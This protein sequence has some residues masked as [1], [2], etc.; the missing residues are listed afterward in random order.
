MGTAKRLGLVVLLLACA[1]PAT[2]SAR[3]R[4]VFPVLGGAT[5][6]DDFGEPR[7]QGAHEGNDLMARKRTP[8]VACADGVVTLHRS[9]RAGF[10]LYLRNRRNEFLYIHLNND[11][12]GDD[13]RGGLR[14]AYAPG[15]R[16]GMHVKMG[17]TIGY[18]GNSGDAKYVGPH[19]H[20]EYHTAS[21]RVLDPYRRLLAA[22]VLLFGA[23]RGSAVQVAPVLRG[24]LAWVADM[25]DGSYR[26]ALRLRSLQAAPGIAVTVRRLVVLRVPAAVGAPFAAAQPGAMLRLETEPR[27][28]TLQ[29]QLMLPG[30][31]VAHA[32]RRLA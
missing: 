20:F 30:V 4:F 28:A 11:I 16:T 19:L 32:I 5:Y 8:V 1:A 22:P 31:F 25:P 10:M 24:R 21:G 26:V 18:V 23:A 9:P 6:Y 14:T 2:A 12:R 17:Q 13:D 3:P 15:L 27:M 7:P 29:A